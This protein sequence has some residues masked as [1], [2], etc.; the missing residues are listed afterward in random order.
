MKVEQLIEHDWRGSPLLATC[1]SLW[2]RL[3]D[4]P[5]MDHYTISTLGELAGTREQ[6]PVLNAAMYLATAKLGV[7]KADL[8]YEV[9]GTFVSVPTEEQVEHA[10]GAPVVHPRTGI[11]LDD[12]DLFVVFLPGPRLERRAPDDA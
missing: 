5:K 6:G 8:L 7:L 12:D 2:R 10:G 4:G 11:P 3:L 9:D 1:L